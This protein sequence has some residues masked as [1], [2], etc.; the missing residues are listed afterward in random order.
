[1]EQASKS[2]N[3]DAPCPDPRGEQRVPYRNATIC[4]SNRFV[5]LLECLEMNQLEEVATDA[6][7]RVSGSAE[8]GNASGRAE[9]GAEASAVGS[10]E[11]KYGAGPLA[12]VVEECIREYERR[13][14]TASKPPTRS[15][16]DP[17]AR[18]RG[19]DDGFGQRAANIPGSRML[20]RLP[21]HL[22]QLSA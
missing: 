3:P 12:G 16:P 20:L 13:G 5:E 2:P 18:A 6:K 19:A 14:P 10:V 11:T 9:L 21:P 17:D 15:F 1:M 4:V 22:P 7:E 8:G